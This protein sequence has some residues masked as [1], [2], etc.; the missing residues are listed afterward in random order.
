MLIYSKDIS[1]DF[2][3]IYLQRTIKFL[4][5]RINSELIKEYSLVIKPVNNNQNSNINCIFLAMSVNPLLSSCSSQSNSNNVIIFLPVI[6]SR[7]SLALT[8]SL[9]YVI[10]H[11]FNKLSHPAACIS[12]SRFRFILYTRSLLENIH[13]ETTEKEFCNN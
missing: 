5:K 12:Y 4:L 3:F 11:A 8:R 2:C 9:L 6:N 13:D 1:K 7:F 10:M